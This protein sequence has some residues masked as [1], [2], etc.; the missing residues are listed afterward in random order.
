M[1]RFKPKNQTSLKFEIVTDKY[2]DFNLPVLIKSGKFEGTVFS[3]NRITPVGEKLYWDFVVH[4]SKFSDEDLHN[5]KE[6]RLQQLMI[7]IALNQE[8]NSKYT[9]H[10]E[11]N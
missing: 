6:F 7:L 5:D 3:F 8:N 11:E 9:T 2:L 1:V 4:E 10:E